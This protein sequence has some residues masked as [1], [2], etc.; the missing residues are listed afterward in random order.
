MLALRVSAARPMRVSCRVLWGPLIV[1]GCE[2]CEEPDEPLE[3]V[4]ERL[5]TVGETDADTTVDSEDT[6]DSVEY[7][8]SFS[9]ELSM[10]TTSV[11][12]PA[13]AQMVEVA[14]ADNDP[15]ERVDMAMLSERVLHCVGT[16]E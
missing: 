12:S 7:C 8:A 1:R 16:S 10:V 9:S 15:S 14:D 6:S 3:V 13:E 11:Y 2:L 4:E 5:A